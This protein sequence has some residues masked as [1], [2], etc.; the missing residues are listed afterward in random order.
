MKKL[1]LVLTLALSLQAAAPTLIVPPGNLYVV[2]I[3]ATAVP[4]S[5]GDAVTQTIWLDTMTLVN[6]TGA[7][8]NVTIADKQGSPVT[9]LPAVSIPANTLV[10]INFGGTRMDSG[11][12]WVASGSGVNGYFKGKLA[13]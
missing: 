9:I 3:Q 1:I 7:P 6:T 4:T 10:V 8:V 2:E 5:T 13:Q 12:T 11:F